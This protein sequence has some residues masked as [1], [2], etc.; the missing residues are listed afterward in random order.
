MHGGGLSL[1]AEAYVMGNGVNHKVII[2]SYINNNCV[3]ERYLF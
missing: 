1:E 2:D 3:S